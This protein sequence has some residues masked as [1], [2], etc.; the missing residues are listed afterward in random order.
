MRRAPIASTRACSDR[1]EHRARLLAARNQPAMHRRVM[2]GHAQGDRIGVAAHDGGVGARE[3]ARRAR[4]GAPCRPPCRAARPRTTPRAR[5]AARSRAGSG[6][7]ALETARSGLPC[8][9]GLGLLL[10]DIKIDLG[11][12]PLESLFPS[13]PRA[14]EWRGD[15]S[16]VGCATRSSKRRPPPRPPSLRRIDPRFKAHSLDPSPS[17][18]R[19]RK[20]LSSGATF[21]ELSGSSWPKQR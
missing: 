8:R 15:G 6:D 1:L 14:C 7:R 11:P 4:A 20:A 10:E 5:D 21:T 19:G 17:A 12:F 9:W 13:P 3:L 16:R 2:A 18:E